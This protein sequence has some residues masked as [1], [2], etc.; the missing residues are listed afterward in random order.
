MISKEIHENLKN[1]SW[2]RRMFVEGAK[3]REQFGDENV[4][5]YSIGNPYFE[6]PKSVTDKL[7]EIVNSDAEGT[8]RYMDNS[9]YKDVRAKVAKAINRDIEKPLGFEHVLMTVGAA[10]GINV[11]LR[12]V[13]DAGD[14]VIIFAP[15]FAEYIFYIRNHNGV[16]VILKTDEKTFEPDMD[17]FEKSITE[18]TRAI[19]IN[20]PNNP[21]GVIY[22]SETLTKLGQI[23]EKKEHEYGREIYLISDEPYKAL[24][25]DHIVVPNIHNFFR[26]SIMVNSYSKSLGLAGERI[27]YIAIN[28]QFEDAELFM[29]G[30]AFANRTLGFV[31]APAIWQKVISDSLEESVDISQYQVR[32]DLLLS[33][34]RNLGFEMVEPKGAF[35]LFPKALEEDDVKFV[36]EAKKFNLLLVPGSGFGSPG[37]FRISY[38]VD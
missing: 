12:T 29:S 23:I 25:Y 6:P 11:V 27:G 18:K 5:D 10:G 1:A 13:L 33:K 14:E 37:Y 32:R 9:G 8:H 2:I 31:N 28:S 22:P 20:S 36:M 24:V 30:L 26:H 17:A 7:K 3:L 4:F 34:L 19:I 15:Y 16:P 35:Y 38:C 21:T